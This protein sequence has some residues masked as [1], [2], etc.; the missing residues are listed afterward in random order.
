MKSHEAA[1]AMI[2]SAIAR[3]R[4]HKAAPDLL[5]VCQDLV[6]SEQYWEEDETPSD[7]SFIVAKA[8]AAIAKVKGESP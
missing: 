4:L 8:K 6:D 2:E 7:L 3:Q 5:A 1:N